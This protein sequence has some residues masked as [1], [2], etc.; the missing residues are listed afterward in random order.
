[1]ESILLGALAVTG[2]NSSKKDKISNKLNKSN[3][4]YSCATFKPQAILLFKD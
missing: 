2:Y 3:K 4:V 1:M